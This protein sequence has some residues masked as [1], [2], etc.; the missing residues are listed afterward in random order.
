M[1]ALAQMEPAV[2]PSHADLA[3]ILMEY[4]EVLRNSGHKAEAANAAAI[5]LSFVPQIPD[6]RHAVDWRDLK[7]P[8]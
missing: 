2:G 5:Q 4:Q 6:R 7:S 8:E 1:L 3:K